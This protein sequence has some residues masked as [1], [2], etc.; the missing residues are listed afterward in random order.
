M[1]GGATIV[2]TMTTTVTVSVD[3]P[4]PELDLRNYCDGDGSGEDHK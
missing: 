3:C 4:S 2:P 1:S